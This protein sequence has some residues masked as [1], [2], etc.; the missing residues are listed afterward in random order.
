MLAIGGLAAYLIISG[1]AVK[2]GGPIPQLTPQIGK[3]SPSS[4]LLVKAEYWLSNLFLSGGDLPGQIQ[5][6]GAAVFLVFGLLAEVWF[7]A[8]LGRIAVA[9]RSQRAAGRVNRFVVLVGV[10]FAIKVLAFVV[11]QVYFRDWMETNV[12]PR[13]VGLEDKW[14]VVASFG[15][16]AV[17]AIALAVLYWR[18][19]GSVRHALSENVD[20]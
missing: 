4:T 11:A 7:V 5:G 12:W 10:L 9:L 13:W 6:I 18:M 3:P 1:L 15:Y 8:T 2:D 19:I 20:G 16:L 17:S 14:K